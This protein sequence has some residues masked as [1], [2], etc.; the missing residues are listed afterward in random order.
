MT[1]RNRTRASMVF[2]STLVV[3][4]L[5][6]GPGVAAAQGQASS[7]NADD[8]Q[9][10]IPAAGPVASGVEAGDAA[11]QSGAQNK[12]AEEPSAGG[13]PSSGEEPKPGTAS[14]ILQEMEGPGRVWGSIRS[15][16][17]IAVGVRA[18]SQNGSETRYA[19]DIDLDSGVRILDTHWVLS[20]VTRGADAAFDRIVIDVNGA[21]GDPYEYYAAQIYKAGKYRIDAR[22]RKADY[23]WA[24]AGDHNVWDTTR[25]FT[26]VAA[27]FNATQNFEV[28]AN[29]NHVSQNG[30]SIRTIDISRN[31][32]EV[33][34]PVDTRGQTWALGGRYRRGG[35]SFYLQ[36]EHYSF[37]NNVPRDTQDN[38]GLVP[39][40]AEI[41]F[42]S[43]QEVQAIDAPATKGGFSSNLVNNRLQ[44]DGDVMYSKQRLAFSFDSYW[45]GLNFQRKELEVIDGALGSGNREVLHGNFFAGFALNRAASVTLRYRH[46]SWDQDAF[47]MVD[48]AQRF[49]DGSSTLTVDRLFTDYSITDNQFLVGAKANVSVGSVYGEV[50]V[51]NRE[52]AF[53]ND[54]F[55]SAADTQTAAFR[56]GG[57]L[58]P[59]RAFDLKA[60]YDY[61]DVDDPFTRISP[62]KVNKFRVRINSRP[63]NGMVVGGHYTY[64]KVEN[65][66]SQFDFKQNGVG[67]HATYTASGGSF[68]TVS[69]NRFDIDQQIP[70]T[71]WLSFAAPTLSTAMQDLANN[72]FTVAAD[73]T[74]SQSFPL[75]VYG[76]ANVVS[77]DSEELGFTGTTTPGA[78]IALNY[79]DV[80][81]GVRYTFPRG[82]F[83]D[84]QGRFIDYQD[85]NVFVNGLDDYD[86]GI[87]TLALGF[88]FD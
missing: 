81:A 6:F 24:V 83:F 12:S 19:K 17:Q 8:A 54:V 56:I 87:F 67:V 31:E 1:M 57:T 28:Y 41:F 62:S 43:E 2:G 79:Y 34:V 78:V 50:G 82:L 13:Q 55:V 9:T 30:D 21:F 5:V 86:A 49:A 60:S 59:S 51:S 75:A 88:R 47:S 44:L 3:L 85:D 20:P 61:G 22:T 4:S 33:D 53:D 74:V 71:F 35:T 10:A 14:P 84:A 7:A 36:Q 46:R 32:F 18:V 25:W 68:V 72:V 45:Q 76:S 52:Q 39:D 40:E 16:G 70:V 42:F 48:S 63:I 69:Y 65:T 38:T 23:K 11:P 29:F 58:R 77:S 64:R 73:V 37:K 66:A 15:E 80:I 26:D 27:N